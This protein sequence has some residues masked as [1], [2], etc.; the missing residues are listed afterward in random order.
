MAD[1]QPASREAVSQRF[2]EAA[3]GGLSRS[4]RIADAIAALELLDD[5]GALMRL[6]E[7]DAETT[8]RQQ[9]AAWPTMIEQIQ[10]ST[11]W[12]WTH[13]RCPRQTALTCG[14]D[15]SRSNFGQ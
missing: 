2:Y 9:A 12:R 13:R 5:V 15:P 10:S 7:T 3:R 8:P 1:L 4:E 14:H 6:T 11:A